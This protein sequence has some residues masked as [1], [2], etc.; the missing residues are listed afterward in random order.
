MCTKFASSVIKRIPIKIKQ[1]HVRPVPTNENVKPIS[2]TSSL[3][4]AINLSWYQN[5]NN[6]V[7]F[8]RHLRYKKNNKY[9]LDSSLGINNFPCNFLLTVIFFKV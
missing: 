2:S 1:D 4:N 6:I 9:K 8:T 7:R 5:M 3:H